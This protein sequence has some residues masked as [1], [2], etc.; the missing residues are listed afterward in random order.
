VAAGVGFWF[1]GLS[2]AVSLGHRKFSPETMLRM[3]RGSGIGLLILGLAHGVHLV[4][5]LAKHRM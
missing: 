5:Q 3:E 4:W 1:V 2:W